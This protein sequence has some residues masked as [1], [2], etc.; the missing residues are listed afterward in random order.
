[1]PIT[2]F[3][4]SFTLGTLISR[5]LGLLREAVFAHLYGSSNATDAFNVA[6]RIPNLLRDLFAETALSAGFVPVFTGEKEK[7]GDQSAMDLATNLFFTLLSLS[8]I[9]V[10]FGIIFAPF[11]V[12]ILAPGF[13][14]IEGKLELTAGLTRITFPFLIFIS[15]A[16][17]AMG[18]LNSYRI[19]F[20]P[21]LAPAL[22][23]LVSIVIPLTTFGLFLRIGLNP[24]YAMAIG[25]TVGGLGQF[26]IQLPLV[27]KRGFRF[28]L[29]LDLG[30]P[31]LRLI[32]TL[33]IPVVAGLAAT[34][35]NVAVDMFLISLLEPKSITY[36]NY[37]YRIMHLPIGLLGVAIST[38]ALPSLSRAF[39]RNKYDELKRTLEESLA[40]AFVLTIP[41]TFLIA[42]LTTP[43]CRFI[44]E[45]GRFLPQDTI[46]TSQALLLYI[47]GVPFVA[48]S[49]SLASAFYSIKKP[50][51]PMIA[52]IYSVI[53][54][55]GLNLTLMW[56]LRFRAFPLAT[57]VSSAFYFGYLLFYLSDEIHGLG[58]RPLF[59]L[60]MR[61]V[62]FSALANI[63]GYTIF[64]L[65]KAHLL[66]RLLSALVVTG[67][68]YYLI[69]NLFGEDRIVR[70]VKGFF[71]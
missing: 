48:G 59:G 24:I 39:A 19:F 14:G 29:R 41:V 8:G 60:V 44:Y 47:I 1:M 54:N 66:I 49:K 9:I 20:I 58:L 15:L 40:H 50:R 5:I 3:V 56:S 13:G 31:R 4:R 18:I 36:I 35:I 26:L 67:L 53:L 69:A 28:R 37:A 2:K 21:S 22:F 30:D 45:H 63:G 32:L 10:L 43:I 64:A 7:K 65:I 55:I 16:A 71:I 38:V 12:R 51:I 68:L 23:N 33:L 17:W 25:V 62:I 42:A 52:S 6:F 70:V 61:V 11:L 46:L 27:L 57:T 34:R